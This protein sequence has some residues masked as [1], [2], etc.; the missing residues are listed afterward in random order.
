MASSDGPIANAAYPSGVE[1]RILGVAAPMRR[2]R[3]FV[4]LPRWSESHPAQARPLDG[5]S[6]D[7][8][9]LKIEFGDGSDWTNVG[10]API[11]GRSEPAGWAVVGLDAH[12]SDRNSKVHEY[13]GP[14]D[15]EKR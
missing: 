4:R 1:F 6:E 11:L 7:F 3:H 12:G 8:L 13:S 5:P 9:R 15:V 14:W 2:L 10:S